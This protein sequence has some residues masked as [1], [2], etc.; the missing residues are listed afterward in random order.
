MAG[1]TDLVEVTKQING[2]LLA[3][4]G[5]Y[6]TTQTDSDRWTTAEV[7]DAAL[8]A[9]LQVCKSFLQK[10]GDGRR[11]PFLLTATVADAGTIPSHIGELDSITISSKMPIRSDPVTIQRDNTNARNLP[12]G[13]Y[14]PKFYLWG[15]KIQHNGPHYGVAGAVVTYADVTRTGACQS[16]SEYSAAVI[17]L[18]TAQVIAKNGD[19]ADA[20]G[21]YL[22]LGMSYLADIGRGETALQPLPTN[23]EAR[24]QMAVAGAAQAG[25]GQ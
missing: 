8:D 7:Q 12:A 22:K 17:A 6:A 25:G 23:E 20:A 11:V 5:V 21:Y 2:R 18:A 1:L 19:R 9:D 4:I 14:V 10:A 16:P 15:N 3:N 24:K 13:T